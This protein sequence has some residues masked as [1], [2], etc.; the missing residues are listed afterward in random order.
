[1]PVSK[2]KDLSPDGKTLAY[3]SDADNRRGLYTLSVNGGE[4]TLLHESDCEEC[5]K[6]VH[7]SPDGKSLTYNSGDGLYLIPSTGGE[8]KKLATLKG[9]ESWTISWS[10]NGEYIAALGYK[11]G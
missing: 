7:W 3:F 1:M 11:E 10:P 4:P 5:C 6:S 8:P 2:E 9:W